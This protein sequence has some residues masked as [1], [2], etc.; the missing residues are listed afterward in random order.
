MSHTNTPQIGPIIQRERKARRLSLE[1]LAALSGVSKSM[2]S[3]IERGAA[4][5]T[6]AVLWSL[7]RALKID[8]SDL[9]GGRA[10]PADDSAIEV[11]TA[12]QTPEIK[13]ADGACRMRILGPPQLVGVTEWYELEMEPGSEL[14][15]APHAPG[16]FEHFTALSDGFEIVSGD[17]SCT[18]NAGETARYRADV[19][20]RITN[21]STK[22]ARGLM[23]LHYR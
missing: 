8:F 22:V 9:V 13:S 15:S 3:Q 5:P 21:R 11:V 18:I 16:A 4:N 19:P 10:A 1:Q 17:Q 6:F 2:L 12:F 23:V 7:T 14:D 20:H